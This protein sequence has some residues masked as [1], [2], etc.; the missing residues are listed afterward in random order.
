[1]N[2]SCNFCPNCGKKLQD[3]PR[4]KRQR[5][6][7]H[8]GSVYYDSRAKRW[9][10]QIVIGKH[11]TE[12]ML[13]RFEYKRQ[14]FPSRT[15]ALQAVAKLDAADKE[16]PAFSVS[17]YYRAFMNGKGSTLS[18][19]KQTAYE[20]AYKRLK[21]L[22][23]TPVKDLTI[24]DLQTLINASCGSYYTAKD[25]RVLLNTIFKLAAADDR[26]INPALPSL[27]QLPKLEETQ[28]EPFTEE[29]QI[30]LWL[31]Y[32]SGDLRAAAPL[33]MIYTGM[34][35]G[36]MLKLS[37]SMIRLEDREIVGVGLKTK[38]RKKKTVLL[39]D[40]IVPVLEDVISKTETELLY[41]M[42]KEIFYKHYYRALTAAGIT[43]KLSPYSC[44]HTTATVLAITE[45]VA[46]Q[47]LQRVMRWKS[48]K[49]M[50][51]YVTPSDHD[52]RKAVN[53]I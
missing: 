2:E 33:I 10:A 26:T 32:E 31:S 27:L 7:N 40:D 46:P 21:P 35:T 28:V 25:V 50:D 49:M 3:L 29:E 45:N 20:I 48:T 51:R 8:T 13:F 18:G 9:V 6:A 1:M 47:T 15:A 14:Y 17:Y 16:K 36:E 52:A 41:P 4:K 23:S 5:R 22:H 11:Y 24:S 30:M 42:S 43:R 34:M 19:S 37:K 44:R 38:E 12:D 39:P 53:R